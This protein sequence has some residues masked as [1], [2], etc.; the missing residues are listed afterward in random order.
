M[1]LLP[2]GRCRSLAKRGRNHIQSSAMLELF[3][4]SRDRSLRSFYWRRRHSDVRTLDQDTFP[5]I[6]AK[7]CRGISMGL[8]GRKSKAHSMCLILSVRPRPEPSATFSPS[9]LSLEPSF[10]PS[11]ETILEIVV[12]SAKQPQ[13]R[14]FIQAPSPTRLNMI[15]LQ[16][17]PTPTF[18]TCDGVEPLTPLIPPE[19]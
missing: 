5:R 15:Q 4:K 1:A 3:C 6:R 8:S 11:L 2:R 13:V 9:R 16:K 7:I 10:D 19:D 14:G 12:R 17:V 18:S